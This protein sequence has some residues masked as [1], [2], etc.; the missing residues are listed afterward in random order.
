[1]AAIGVI[2]AA[3]SLLFVV[4]FFQRWEWSLWLGT[5]TLTV[6]V[7]SMATFTYGTLANGAW[8]SNPMSYLWIYIPFLPVV[9]LFAMVGM[10]TVQRTA[11]E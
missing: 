8:S 6:S 4:G 3:L 9:V 11:Q 10:W 2:N 7:H 5:L 1:M